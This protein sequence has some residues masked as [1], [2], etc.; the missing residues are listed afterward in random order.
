MPSFH[1][2][3]ALWST[4]GAY[5][6]INFLSHYPDLSATILMT[7]T[8]NCK[9]I[10]SV[11]EADDQMEDILGDEDLM[12][13][14]TSPP[15]FSCFTPWPRIVFFA[16]RRILSIIIYSFSSWTTTAGLMCTYKKKEIYRPH[17]HRP[18]FSGLD[19]VGF[20]TFGL[21]LSRS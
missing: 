3:N 2:P 15:P 21:G 11:N 7:R 17:T 9:I 13:M 19:R 18:L 8:S 14:K 12:T 6:F 10:L 20:L 1:R 5:V 16:L 4:R